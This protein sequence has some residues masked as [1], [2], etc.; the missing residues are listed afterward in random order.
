MYI[1]SPIRLGKNVGKDG[2]DSEFDSKSEEVVLNLPKDYKIIAER[3]HAK[4][5]DAGAIAK[6]SEIDREHLDEEGHMAIAEAIYRNISD[7]LTGVD[8]T[9]KRL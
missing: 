6:P 7:V 9:L 3:H 2:Y 1:I 4:F 8:W 5:L